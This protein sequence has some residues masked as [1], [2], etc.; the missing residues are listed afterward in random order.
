[1]GK[2]MRDRP[3]EEVWLE[4][5]QLIIKSEK[6]RPYKPYIPGDPSTKIIAGPL[7]FRSKT[8]LLYGAALS[9]AQLKVR[10]DEMLELKLI[11]EHILKNTKKRSTMITEYTTTEKGR[12]LASLLGKQLEMIDRIYE[13]GREREE[14]RKVPEIRG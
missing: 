2:M 9:T 1:M 10:I 4:I 7:N 5:L 8:G 14:R 3:R 13:V 11:E 12:K 6:Q